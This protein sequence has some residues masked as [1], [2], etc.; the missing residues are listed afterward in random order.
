LEILGVIEFTHLG[1]NN[2]CV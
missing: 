1:F 2:S